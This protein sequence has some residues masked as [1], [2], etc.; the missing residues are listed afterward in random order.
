MKESVELGPLGVSRECRL[1]P[2][3][4]ERDW[5]GLEVRAEVQTQ[6]ASS[7][8]VFVVPGCGLY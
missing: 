3:L 7:S 5:K 4:S 6:G 8:W 1:N 2:E